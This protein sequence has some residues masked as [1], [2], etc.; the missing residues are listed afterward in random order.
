VLR[1]FSILFLTTR[2]NS[3]VAKRTYDRWQ[4]RRRWFTVFGIVGIVMLL[5]S[6]AADAFLGTNI[7]A[8]VVDPVCIMLGVNLLGYVIGRNMDTKEPPS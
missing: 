3:L 8:N 1:L 7:T 4:F 5:G 6:L 2:V